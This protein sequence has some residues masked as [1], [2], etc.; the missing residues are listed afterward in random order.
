MENNRAIIAIALIILLWSGYSMFFQPQQPPA[1]VVEQQAAEQKNI[2]VEQTSPF[3]ATNIEAVVEQKIDRSNY[4]EKLITVSSELF[5]MTLSTTGATIRGI[6]LKQFKES[7]DEDA[8]P[9][10]YMVM[11][12]LKN[13]T[14]QTSGSEGLSIPTDMPFSLADGTPTSVSVDADKKVVSFTAQTS[15]G[16][17]IVKSYIFHADSYLVDV[18]VELINSG[19]TSLKGYFN[20]SLVSLDP[21]AEGEGM[22]NMYSFV[23]PLSFDGEELIEDKVEDLESSAKI[24]GENIVWSGNV[25]KY[26]LT[27]MAAG[28]SAKQIQIEKADTLIRNK[29]ISPFISLDAGQKT[30][31]DYTS[32]IGPKDY[33]LLQAAGHQFEFAKDYGFFAVLAKPLMHVLKFFYGYLGNYGLAIILLTI[34][35]KVIFWPL[36]QKSYKSMKGMQKL[37]PEMQ[38]MRE[39]YGSDKQRLNQEMMTFYKENKVNPLGGCLPMLIQIPVF[40]ALY[41]VLLGAIEL[42]HAPF[43][44]WIADLSAKDPYYI[45]PLIMGATMFIQQKMTPTNMDPNQAKIM[46]MMPVV[47]TFLFLNFPSG[48]VIYWM[49]NNLLTILQQYLIKRQPD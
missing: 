4:Q 20:L 43:M 36:T 33:D 49:V 41:Q 16:L 14:F 44:F 47:F 29:F 18:N 22:Q 46:L 27:I 39:K 3:T 21:S 17:T 12:D 9:F 25:S 38:K 48:L 34:C 42:R 8:K 23:G 45:T 30:V 37:Q 26:F 5:E 13:A 15:S 24:Y 40:F 1:P 10:E 19:S 7:N 35:I 32:F 28:D 11:S 6:T 31:L 2:A